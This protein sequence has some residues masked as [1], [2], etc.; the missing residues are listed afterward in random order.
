MGLG[1]VLATEVEVKLTESFCANPSG[2]SYGT[3][4]VKTSISASE[5]L[6]EE[7][8]IFTTSLAPK[9][10]SKNNIIIVT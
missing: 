10:H 1:H 5:N 4:V 7:S 8:L 9:Q 2:G 6:N 3:P